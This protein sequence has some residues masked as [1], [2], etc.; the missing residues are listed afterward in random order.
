MDDVAPMDFKFLNV[1]PQLKPIGVVYPSPVSHI[2]IQQDI[3]Q[4]FFQP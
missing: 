4:M 2:I 1:S 3:Y